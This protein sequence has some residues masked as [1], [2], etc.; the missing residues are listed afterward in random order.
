[1]MANDD[2]SRGRIFKVYLQKYI[3]EYTLLCSLCGYG[4]SYRDIAAI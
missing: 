4:Y 1:M 3:A 2:K